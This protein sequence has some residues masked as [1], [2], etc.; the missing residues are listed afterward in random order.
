MAW[1]LLFNSIWLRQAALPASHWG[2]K[3]KQQKNTVFPPNPIVYLASFSCDLNIKT[4]EGSRPSHRFFFAASLPF[5]SPLRAFEYV[6]SETQKNTRLCE[7]N[8]SLINIC[9]AVMPYTAILRGRG[10]WFGAIAGIASLKGVLEW[11]LRHS[12][13]SYSVETFEWKPLITS[14]FRYSCEISC[15]KEW[16]LR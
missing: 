1:M 12:R 11:E 6:R 15:R 5:F 8:N 7:I 2:E 14:G 13:S 3:E 16:Q 10:S 9:F 4:I